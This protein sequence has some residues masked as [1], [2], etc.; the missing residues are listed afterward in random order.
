MSEKQIETTDSLKQQIQERNLELKKISEDLSYYQFRTTQ[1]ITKLANTIEE[2]DGELSDLQKELIYYKKRTTALDIINFEMRTL[3]KAGKGFSDILNLHKLLR[4]FMAVVCEK[5]TITKASVMLFDDIDPRRPHYQVKAYIG[6][7]DY[8]TNEHKEKEELMLFKMPKSE[9]LLWQS[10]QQGEVISVRDLKKSPR[11]KE[12][13]DQWDLHILDAD[14]WCPIIKNG[15]VLGILTL[16][17][18]TDGSTV[19]ESEYQYIQDL[20]SIVATNIDST[21]K[22]E[23]TNRILD[24]IKILYDVNQQLANVQDFKH[25]CI[26]TIKRACEAVKAQRANMMLVD[27]ETEKLVLKVV[28]GDM[29][30]AI[31][32]MINHGTGTV[33]K[34]FQI[35]EGVAGQC[36]KNK[37]VIRM[38]D[39]IQIQQV[40]NQTVYAIMSVPM[41][42][43]NKVVGVINCTNKVKSDEKD[44]EL[45]TLGRFTEEDEQLMIGLADQ[46]ATNLQKAKLYNASIT[47]RMT[48]LFNTRHFDFTI[49]EQVQIAAQKNEPMTLIICDIDHFKNFNDTH[50]HKAGDLVLQKVAEAIANCARNYQQDRCFRYGGEEFC[51][52]MSN[53]STKEAL[54]V[55]EVVRKAVEA[56][57]IQYGD[58]VMKVTI[59]LGVA[60]Y[61]EAGT[62]QREI[63]EL[64]DKCLYSA[65]ENGRNQVQFFNHATNEFVNSTAQ[66]ANSPVKKTEG[67]SVAS[68]IANVIPTE[69]L[70]VKP[71]D[72]QAVKPT[73]KQAVEPTEKPAV[74]LT[75]TPIEKKT[76]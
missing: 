44:W 7:N 48:G 12:A 41:L 19:M 64:S 61:P 74:K 13:F 50:G 51:L 21:L 53:T 70:V 69:K 26:E 6:L 68:P 60:T 58:K 43:D 28:W 46:A 2:K 24:N 9:G 8:Y 36:Y 49:E 16:G 42:Q 75:G 1:Q 37:K 45:D 56:M 10:I 11:F 63:F 47:D 29:P 71:T 73:E 66:L 27:P 17:A 18:K 55:A 57:A 14:V 34:S 33:P 30:T 39:K 38:N 22:F 40:G 35:G 25:L 62:T 4:I 31:R 59:S 20:A 72:K 76:A 23:K 5:F 67:T 3:L 32:D 65:K 15:F 52:I 54:P